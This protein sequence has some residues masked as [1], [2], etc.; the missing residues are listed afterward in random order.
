M[1]MIALCLLLCGCS[2]VSHPTK[3]QTE[4]RDDL[5]ACYEANPLRFELG[6]AI[7]RG[8]RVDACMENKGWV[9]Q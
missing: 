7:A 4:Y 9:R 8:V 2:T 1:R 6:M 3:P 5:M